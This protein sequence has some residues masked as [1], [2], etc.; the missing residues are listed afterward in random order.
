MA[1]LEDDGRLKFY[2]EKQP[3]A[4]QGVF[5]A[6]CKTEGKVLLQF[7]LAVIQGLTEN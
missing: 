3:E 4:C 2:L 6:L 1:F 7:M 5:V